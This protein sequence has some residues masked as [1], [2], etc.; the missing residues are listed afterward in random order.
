MGKKH[1]TWRHTLDSPLPEM[2]WSGKAL[3]E[4]LVL[5]QVLSLE[6]WRSGSVMSSRIFEADWAGPGTIQAIYCSDGL[7]RTSFKEIHIASH[8]F[9]HPTTNE[10]LRL[11]ILRSYT[12]NFWMQ[13]RERWRIWSIIAGGVWEKVNTIR[14]EKIISHAS[15]QKW[16]L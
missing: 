16:N 12:V 5:C 6:R 10:A 14:L 9:L 15:K 3:G 11:S 13:K 7:E 1:L 4:G 8:A 2:F